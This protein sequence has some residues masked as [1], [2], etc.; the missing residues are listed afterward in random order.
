MS[1]EGV[2]SR[3]AEYTEQERW[4]EQQRL[5]L[6]YYMEQERGSNMKT[7]K[8]IRKGTDEQKH[9]LTWRTE[10]GPRGEGGIDGVGDQTNGRWADFYILGLRSFAA[11]AAMAQC[12]ST[13]QASLI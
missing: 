9:E 4:M 13:A 12:I 8:K 5:Q 1:S 11:D 10:I 6:Y 2:S 3:L 7:C